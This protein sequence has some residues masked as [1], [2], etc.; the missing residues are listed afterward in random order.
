MGRSR[1]ADAETSFGEAPG[2]GP[3]DSTLSRYTMESA[4]SILIAMEGSLP[5]LAIRRSGYA[6]TFM[7]AENKLGNYCFLKGIAPYSAGVVAEVGF[8]IIHV[9]LSRYVPL[10]GEV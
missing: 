7:L 2:I 8:E 4:G 6:H 3:E 5:P 10:L 1:S 9:R